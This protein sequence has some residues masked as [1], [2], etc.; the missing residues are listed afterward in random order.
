[1]ADSVIVPRHKRK[2]HHWATIAC[3]ACASVSC[4]AG[5]RN[6]GRTPEWGA[7]AAARI[8]SCAASLAEQSAWFRSPEQVEVAQIELLRRYVPECFAEDA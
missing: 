1:M 7:I 3:T 4:E 2:P 8:A 6:R 5:P